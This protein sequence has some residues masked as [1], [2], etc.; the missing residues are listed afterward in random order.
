MVNKHITLSPLKSVFMLN[1]DVEKGSNYSEEVMGISTCSSASSDD[2]KE[3]K[4]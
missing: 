2:L 1:H 3:S 4:D